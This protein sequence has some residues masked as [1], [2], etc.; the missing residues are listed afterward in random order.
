MS[1]SNTF[2]FSSHLLCAPWLC[3]CFMVARCH[4]RGFGDDKN[5]HSPLP[6]HLTGGD[7]ETEGR[8]H[9]SFGSFHSDTFWWECLVLYFLIIYDTA[10]LVCELFQLMWFCCGE[11]KRC[12]INV[13]AL[14]SN[15]HDEHTPRDE[16][17]T[18]WII[19]A[20]FIYP[21]SIQVHKKHI[22]Y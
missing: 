5:Q 17:K 22:S 1:L 7:M 8:D 9:N 14:N 15:Q 19:P 2:T 10:S 20:A 12:F 11:Y 18:N 6:A 21:L 13:L 3:Q 4:T 16:E